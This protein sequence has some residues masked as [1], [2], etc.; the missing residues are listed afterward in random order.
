MAKSNSYGA[1]RSLTSILYIVVHY[2][3]VVGDT[4]KNEVKFFATGNT[5]SAGA[6]YFVGQ[7]GDVQQSIPIMYR[8][9]SVGDSSNGHGSYYGKCTNANSVSIEMC[10]QMTK[11][12]S[13]AQ[14]KAVAGVIKHIL[15]QCPNAKTVIRHYD[16]TTKSCPAR[17]LSAS[18]WSQLKAALTDVGADLTFVDAAKYQLAVDGY[19]GSLTVSKWQGVL[20]TPQDGEI[21]GQ[22]K[23]L[24]KYHLNF[25]STSIDYGSGGS[26]LIRKVQQVLGVEVDGQLGP[27]TIKAIQRRV[28]VYPDGY[29][30]RQTASALQERLNT[31]S[32]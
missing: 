2:T 8:A 32:F 17:Y 19:A 27:E 21:S 11:D 13:A 26:T 25:T 7:D 30:G 3:G 4:A 22:N 29:F 5:R 16:V 1:V 28:G 24:K 10:D 18:K 23:G 14:I 9:W 12:A 6:H 31:G 15:S 20:G